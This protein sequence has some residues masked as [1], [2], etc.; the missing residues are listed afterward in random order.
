MPP[1]D[2]DHIHRIARLAR[3]SLSPDEAADA[4]ARLGAVLG[5]VQRLQELPLDAEPM[6]PTAPG[7]RLDED[8]PGPMLPR[9]ILLDIAPET[10]ES[11]IRVPKVIDEASG[12]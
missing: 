12:A 2:P 9:D 10:W 8:E 4:R 7:N 5:Y 1:L 11:F 3:L 6:A